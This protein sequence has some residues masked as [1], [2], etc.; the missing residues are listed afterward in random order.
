MRAAQNQGVDFV[1]QKRFQVFAHRQPRDFVVEPA[2]F[3]QRHEQRC[4]LRQDARVGIVGV[5]GTGIGIAVHC[6]VGGNNADV[7]VARGGQCSLRP[8]FNHA[9]HRHVAGHLLHFGSGNGGNCIAGNHQGFDLVLQ[10]EIDNLQRKIFNRVARL[11]TVRHARGVAEIDNVFIGQAFHQCTDD[12]EAAH[13]GI[14]NTDRFGVVGIHGA[15]L[16]FKVQAAFA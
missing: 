9:Q 12:G 15:Y 16:I 6:G 11:H 14:E 1:G 5:D 13:A 8:G 2:F 3:H 7:V 4:G 10:Q